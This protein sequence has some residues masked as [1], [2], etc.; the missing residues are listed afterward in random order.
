MLLL[1]HMLNP[2]RLSSR[3]IF[4]AA[5]ATLAVVTAVLLLVFPPWETKKAELPMFAIEIYGAEENLKQNIPVKF[6]LN[7]NDTTDADLR[8][9]LKVS[10][11]KLLHVIFVRENFDFFVHI[12]PEDE[13]VLSD[14]NFKKGFFPFE[15]NF[16]KEGKYLVAA[17][18]SYRGKPVSLAKSVTIGEP[19]SSAIKKD[20]TNTGKFGKYTVT[21]D[22][23]GAISS[24]ENS[25]I[26]FH[27]E[28]DGKPVGD[29]EPYLG[30]PMHIA[31][32][33]EDLGY[34]SHT[35]GN[36]PDTSA[37]H[38]AASHEYLTKT[39]GPD[40]FFEH[41]FPKPGFYAVFG[42]FKRNGEVTLIK[43]VLDVELSG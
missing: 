27:I 14:E 11:E 32:V 36:V 26:N 18:F 15:M 33:S 10:H 35:H 3:A 28:E 12:H 5:A 31:I 21:L 13:S 2:S 30:A 8:E 16:P 38:T 7:I 43:F 22:T 25:R 24:G 23:G 17:D 1:R 6:S 34:F 4:G 39:M 9:Y 40:I 29:I 41:S 42:E 37:P 19:A 20:L